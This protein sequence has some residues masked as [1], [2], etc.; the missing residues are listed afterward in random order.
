MKPSHATS[1]MLG[2][3]GTLLLGWL[4]LPA[5]AGT[6]AASFRSLP[7]GA[8]AWIQKASGL[9][10]G[11]IPPAQPAQGG[12]SMPQ[13]T[14]PGDQRGS[15]CS[16]N[17]SDPGSPPSC[18]AFSTTRDCSV[19]S[20]DNGACSALGSPAGGSG[21]ICS[22][23]VAQAQCSIIPPALDPPKGTGGC[24]VDLSVAGQDIRCS[25]MGTGKGQFC[26]TENAGSQFIFC[27]VFGAGQQCSV[28]N[29]GAARKSFCSVARPGVTGC[30]TLAATGSC[31]V[32]SGGRGI[33]TTLQRAPKRAC[34]ALGGG[35]CSVI[36]GSSGAR[37][38]QP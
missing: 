8:P 3:A 7:P 5:D 30:S 28:L 34:S 19:R 16:V 35:T 23:F 37:C 11:A 38:Q 9:L 6:A 20:N 10:L 29:P 2:L 32:V 17:A 22:T 21:A 4:L 36:G 27:S 18:S 25:A 31:S 15:L 13:S 1:R 33:C 14:I 24:S 26:S 12:G